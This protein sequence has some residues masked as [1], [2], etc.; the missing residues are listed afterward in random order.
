MK[1]KIK[2][3]GLAILCLL[4]IVGLNQIISVFK[5]R[6]D[7]TTV[8]AHVIRD[9]VEK[10]MKM[11]TLEANYS[12]IYDYKSYAFA[13]IWPLRKKA[14]IKVQAKVLA[15]Y[16]LESFQMTIDSLHKQVHIINPSAPQIIS[17][18][19]DLDY[20]SFEN[21]WFNMIS[22]RDITEMGRRAKEQIRT[23]AESGDLLIKAAEQ[24]KELIEILELS[25]KAVGWTLIIESKPSLKG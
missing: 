2:Y 15:G 13:D 7:T 22:N 17:I 25:L 3:L 23:H 18:E 11:V 24:K 19:T 16:D 21:G 9:R 10:V 1:N 6:N 4:A 8:E 20:Y 12:E 14:L 5:N